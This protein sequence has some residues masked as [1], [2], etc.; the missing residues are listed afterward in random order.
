QLEARIIAYSVFR[1][2]EYS[3]VADDDEPDI[4]DCGAH[5][6]IATL[7]FKHLYPKARVTAIEANPASFE[8][9]DHN[10]RVNKLHN[11]ETIWGAVSNRDGQVVLHIDP[12][13]T[14]PWS[15]GDSIVRGMW[16]PDHTTAE[17]LVPAV[18]LSRYIDRPIDFLKLDI[19]GA[20]VEVME[21]VAS[22]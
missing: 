18:K 8:L 16:G 20:E 14:T 9:L 10:V 6:G 22:A 21:E 15:W 2:G 3:F 13:R 19:E 11:V 7:Y 5:I 1:R 17:I 4:I 12:D